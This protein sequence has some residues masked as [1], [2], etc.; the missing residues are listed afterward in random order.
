[1]PARRNAQRSGAPSGLRPFSLAL[2]ACPRRRFFASRAL[3]GRILWSVSEPVSVRRGCSG[4]RALVGRPGLLPSAER[5]S[6][7][8]LRQRMRTYR[9][10][11]T[12]LQTE[13]QK[14]RNELS[15]RLGADRAAAVT[16]R[17]GPPS[18]TC[19]QREE[20]LTIRDPVR[21]IKRTCITSMRV[22]S[23]D[24]GWGPSERRRRPLVVQFEAAGWTG[25]RSSRLTSRGG[26][27]PQT[28]SGAA[29]RYPRHATRRRLSSRRRQT[30]HRQPSC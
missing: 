22:R 10:E 19:I 8:S 6:V 2:R 26:Q 9:D 28:G 3:S 18:T 15:R 5:A 20:P 24:A 11:I 23:H 13:N 12:R 25:V 7:D 27:L 1:M 14:L 16:K 29:G 30:C 21:G 4:R 17:S